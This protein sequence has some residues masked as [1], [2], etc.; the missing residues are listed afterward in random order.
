MLYPLLKN[1]MYGVLK[2]FVI[3]ILF[4]FWIIIFFS[5]TDN[6]IWDPSFYYG[7][8]RSPIVDHDLDLRNE[9][10]TGRYVLAH[11]K[12]GLQESP[13]PIGPSILWSPSFLIT[14]TIVYWLNPSQANGFDPLSLVGVAFS[15]IGYGCA[16]L[17][18]IYSVCRKLTDQ[19]TALFIIILSFLATPLFYYMFR[20]P[21]M[22]HT[23]SLFA[24][25]LVVW[26]YFHLNQYDSVDS[27][28]GL[29][30]GIALGL[31]F[32]TRWT[33]IVMVIIPGVYFIPRIFYVLKNHSYLRVKQVILQITILFLVFFAVI[34]PQLSLWYRLH[35]S[36]FVIPQSGD[37]FIDGFLP[38]NTL[39]VFFH[40]NRGLLFWAPFVMIGILGIWFI[41]DI[42]IRFA[43]ISIILIQVILI[44]YRVDWY[45]GGGFGARY[46]IENL[47][48]LVLGVIAVIKKMRQSVSFLSKMGLEFLFLFFGFILIVHQS[49]L[50]VSYENIGIGWINPGY[51]SGADIG[52]TWLWENFLRL[53]YDP[54]LWM[55]LHPFVGQ[56]RQAAIVN[57]LTGIRELQ[58]Y[59]IP[60]ISTIITPLLISTL[61]LFTHLLNKHRL[62]VLLSIIACYCVIWA[63]FLLLI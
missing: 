34:T 57:Y 54:S 7:Q 24:F 60:Y 14:H 27:L 33:G 42:P 51:G 37:A 26:V 22:A 46:M 20:Q 12:T 62:A 11:T 61:L 8:M 41:P 2:V 9:T 3:S 32:L 36:F 52:I 19:Y 16:G 1:M 4:I 38:V 53:W 40:S 23:A 45:S 49:M 58:M 48:L 43:T 25:S 35:L 59:M 21:I 50:L 44:G 39:N 17:I 29:L 28:S 15:S 30:F 55:A 5:P 31:C 18:L 10:L 13:W 56:D 47:P 6:W 63:G